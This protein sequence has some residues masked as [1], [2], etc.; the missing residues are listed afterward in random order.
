MSYVTFYDRAGRPTAWIGSNTDY[1]SIFLFD[2]RPVAWISEDSI[3]AYSG[4]HLG[5]FQD[6]WIRDHHGKAVFFIHGA[7]GGPAKPARQARPA[8]GAR[9][10]RPARAAR[11]S[12]P[13]RAARTASWSEL[14]GL[15]FFEQ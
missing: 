4:K 7:K 10:A 3:Y 15:M 8:R 11:K 2:G 12:R 9:K 6:G 14:S 1:P 13:A 5:F